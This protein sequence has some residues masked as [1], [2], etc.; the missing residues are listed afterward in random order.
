MAVQ[1]DQPFKLVYSLNPFSPTG[2]VIEP[3]V[4][5]LNEWGNP[6]LSYQR[7]H[8]SN[9]Y[10]YYK[11][12][13]KV[14]EDLIKIMDEYSH[15]ALARRFSKKNKNRPAE[16]LQIELTE[17]FKQQVIQPYIEK[18]MVQVLSL[19]KAE[20]GWLYM[21]SKSGNP[22][23]REI[24]ILEE[25]ASV[26]FHFI[27]Q[28]QG[29]TYY[30]TI[31]Q[32]K[33]GLIKLSATFSQL[34]TLKPCWALVDQHLISFQD[35]LDGK[36]LKPFIKRGSL[37]IPERSEPE[38]YRKFIP[39]VIENHYVDATG[40][41][42]KKERLSP[43]P[44]LCLT[45]DM[46]GVPAFVLTFNYGK[47][48]AFYF[49]EQRQFKVDLR[50]APETYEFLKIERDL[51]TEEAYVEQ[52]KMQGLINYQGSYFGIQAKNGAQKAKPLSN[53]NAAFQP[54]LDWL[55]H[56]KAEL[57]ALDFTIHQAVPEGQF[58]L[59]TPELVMNLAENPKN[60]DWF[61]LQARVYFGSYSIP[62]IRLKPYIEQGIREYPLPSG[63]VALLPESWF[64][65]YADLFAF[66]TT[67][68]TSEDLLH[69]RKHHYQLLDAEH[70]KAGSAT[71]GKYIQALKGME[72]GDQQNKGLPQTLNVSLRDY[73][74]EGYRW[75]MFLR[76]Q[77]FGGCLADDMGLGKTLQTLAAI[78]KD[79][80]D[81][82]ANTGESAA[83]ENK[84]RM[85]L[86]IMPASLLHNWRAEILKFTPQ[87]SCLVYTGNDRG[88]MIRWFEHYDV[89]LTTYGLARNDIKL[90]ERYQFNYIILDESQVIKNPSSKSAKAV[91]QLNSRYRLVLTGTP[92]ENSL[93]D[94][95][96]QMAFLNPGLLGSY[97]FFKKTY[98]VPIEKQKDEAKRNKLR[99]LIKPFLLRRT[100]E[101][102]SE[103]LPSLTEKTHYCIMNEA[104]QEEYD[105]I[106]SYYRN[107]ILGNVDHYGLQQSQFMILRGITQLRLASNHPKLVNKD[108]PS[109]ASKFDEI[110][111]K[112]E[113]LA[114][115]GHKILVF[116]Q[117]VKHLDFL[118]ASLEHK[119]IG[120]ALLTG[121]SRNREQIIQDFRED[122]QK[123]V[124]LISLKA[125]GVGLN[126][127]EADYVFIA[128][129]WW[130]PATESQAIN[131]AHRIG[132]DK[133][134][135]AYKFITKGTIEEK[136]LKLQEQKSELV[137]D[138]IQ[139]NQRLS[140]QLTRED[141]EMLLN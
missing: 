29:T 69:L 45:K 35:D 21:N 49:H 37:Q 99:V 126:L 10:S 24:T 85:N 39:Q 105:R 31:K 71:S 7:I 52:L 138:V 18:R 84:G 132:Q 90:L 113:E 119:G 2:P 34:I 68:P 108:Y 72:P 140:Y 127:V 124:F 130:N 67:T 133:R 48:T 70:T 128:D 13:A 14:D 57:E 62:F 36:K 91:K 25:P 79:K 81:A 103:E 1:V 22:T 114:A 129:P 50:E 116:S 121:S 28:A 17:D 44:V 134:V 12:L 109:D 66:L 3:F 111:Q 131:R 15:Q 9:I 55:K 38:F 46:E 97:R 89:I 83:D 123:P 30:P 73:Q 8:E 26:H 96:S 51:P 43:K 101:E 5:Q 63:E 110:L 117:F 125:G 32:A 65:K 41:S 139:A 93:M 76:E 135:I 82:E 112:V 107:Q 94:L 87:L 106:K 74:K 122:T 137:R 27:K 100:K 75:L 118:K 102:I 11:R 136:I 120:Y 33:T 95:W 98:G 40:F 61:D 6:T 115:S 60:H 59:G 78:L 53:G 77:G 56:Y 80:E 58:Y 86:V 4:V 88:E 104:Q 16:F 54:L 19:I 20:H 23:S 47:E 92:I 141:L 64:T 42:I